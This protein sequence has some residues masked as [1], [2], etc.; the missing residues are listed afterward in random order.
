MNNPKALKIVIALLTIALITSLVFLGRAL[1]QNF[2]WEEEVHGHVG[3]V[4]ARQALEDFQQGRLRLRVID[5]ENERLRYSGSNDG[6]FE[7]WVAPF[8]P[9]LGYPHR[10]ATEQELKFYNGKMRYMYAHPERFL[11][12]TNTGA[13]KDR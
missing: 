12:A 1:W 7:I 3:M 11:T 2:W 8:R 5:G 13:R 6:P 9:S 10:F 4:A